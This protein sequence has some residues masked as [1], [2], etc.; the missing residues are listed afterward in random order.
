M[1]KLPKE[2]P[3]KAFIDNMTEA[4]I[5][6]GLL[7]ILLLFTFDIIRPFVLPIIWGA[8]LAVALMPLTRKLQ[9][10]FGGRQGL[11]AATV[12]L[13]GVVLLIAPLTLVSHSIY[14]DIRQVLP[15][16]HEGQVHIPGPTARV[17][18]IPLIG[19]PLFDAWSQFTTNLEQAIHHF[20]PEIRTLLGK[21][22]GVLGST[23]SSIALFVIALLIAAGFMA[24]AEKMTSALRTVATRVAGDNATEWN[25][26]MAA[27]VR[28]VL[29]GVIGV[30]FIQTAIIGSAFFVF[31]I[32]GAGILSLLLLFLCIAQVPALLIVLPL[33]GYVFATGE[34]MGPTLF[35]VWAVLGGLSDNVLKPML[36]GRGVSI[37]MPV[38]L[39]GAIG[40][41]LFA[42]IIGLFLGAIILSLWYELF[43][44]WL[45]ISRESAT[46]NSP[47]A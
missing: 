46:P 44:V 21:F 10:L 4:A 37:P 32:P 3:D 6:I 9:A 7:A 41:M 40:G 19:Q 35:A 33:I 13:L 47:P 45:G 23:L 31:D 39:L 25:S 28:S 1:D 16:L 15:S 42:G 27:I 26:L 8:I 5:R 30:A 22:A 17:A 38:I 12:A 2:G 18:A 24:N 20:L 14:V 11:A 43:I 29:I 36:M 34:G